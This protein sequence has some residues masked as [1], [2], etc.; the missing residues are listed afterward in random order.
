MAECNG[1]RC[2]FDYS[3]CGC[4]IDSDC[5]SP[6]LA[7][8]VRPTCNS[9]FACDFDYSACECEINAQCDDGIACTEDICFV[10]T[11]ACIHIE[12]NCD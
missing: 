12:S 3:A 9:A 5:A 10:S 11:R 1:N 8:C 7:S 6:R 4:Q 2:D